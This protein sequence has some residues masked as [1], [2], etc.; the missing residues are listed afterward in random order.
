MAT[1]SRGE[2][3]DADRVR[4]YLYPIYDRQYNINQPL[5]AEVTVHEE[6]VYVTFPYG[7][8]QISAMLDMG[9]DQLLLVTASTD[10]PPL[11]EEQTTALLAWLI[12]NLPESLYDPAQAFGP[13]FDE[14][15]PEIGNRFRQS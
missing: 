5:P 1:I 14:G 11:D 4:G 13:G 9:S 7:D 3:S 12:A 8:Q 2:G 6:G 10:Y 15:G